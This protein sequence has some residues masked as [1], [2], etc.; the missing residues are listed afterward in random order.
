MKA[1]GMKAMSWRSDTGNAS[2]EFA[3]VA[4]L[5]MLIALAVLQLMLAIH[6]R[7]VIT[8]AAIE[9][10][11][12]GALVGSDLSQAEQRTRQVLANNIAGAAVSEV[13]AMETSVG[14]TPMIAVRVAAELPLLGLYG[15]TTMSLT[16]HAF[17]E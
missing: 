9:G 11:R 1:R 13:T 2:V 8:S 6:V 10:A 12:V 3:L 14:A 7:T 4:P 5:L 15:P 17:K 16:G